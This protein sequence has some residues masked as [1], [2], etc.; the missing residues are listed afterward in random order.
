[1]TSSSFYW[2]SLGQ[3]Y[4]FDPSK[5][6]L[7]YFK[8]CFCPPHRG[9]FNTVKQL[10]DKGKNIHAMIHQMGAEARHGVPKRLNREIW[11]LYVNELLPTDRIHLVQY[12]STLDI[13]D[14][15]I[16]RDIDTVVYIRGNEGYEVNATE[17]RDR[18]IFRRIISNLER[19][20]VNMDFYYME[21]PLVK[22]LSAS[23]FVQTLI[24]TRGRCKQQ[25]CDCKYKRQSYF[26]PK[27]LSRDTVL[28]IGRKLQ[29]QDLK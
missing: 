5:K 6:Y 21:R 22:T 14:Q 12:S 18:K 8:G 23:K 27:G 1:M 24:N 10:V 17:M 20:N 11:R 9:H 29:K 13:F 16:L 4:P 15:K 25:G 3:E 2:E 26:M 7:I 28:R 19:I